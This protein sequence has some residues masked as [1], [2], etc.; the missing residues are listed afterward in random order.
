[1]HS[2]YVLVIMYVYMFCRMPRN[3]VTAGLEG[4]MNSEGND[5]DGQGKVAEVRVDVGLKKDNQSV[6]HQ[7]GVTS[8]KVQLENGAE[9]LS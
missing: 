5:G 1:M 2:R 7:G 9:G 8:A 3:T 4:N 6:D